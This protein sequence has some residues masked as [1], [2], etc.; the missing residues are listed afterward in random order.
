VPPT[1]LLCRVKAAL[2]SH[3]EIL[4]HLTKLYTI[5]TGRSAYC[6]QCRAK[7]NGITSDVLRTV[8]DVTASRVSALQVVWNILLCEMYNR[9][10]N[11]CVYICFARW[12]SWLRQNEDAQVNKVLCIVGSDL[13]DSHILWT[14]FDSKQSS[15]PIIT[16]CSIY[17][18][19]SV[20]LQYTWNH[21]RCSLHGLF[22][23]L[24]RIAMHFSKILKLRL[25]YSHKLHRWTK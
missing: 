3:F 14:K 22:D 9:L 23:G 21:F 8:T 1:V 7:Q 5:S 4:L 6:V 13:V 24:L 2:D 16:W 25:A 19:F 20:L 11:C 18:N 17:D 12:E 15:L 10:V